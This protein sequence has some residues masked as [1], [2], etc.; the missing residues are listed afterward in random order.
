MPKREARDLAVKSAFVNLSLHK[1]HKPAIALSLH[2]YAE[3][4]VVF[5]PEIFLSTVFLI[6]K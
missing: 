6:S 1:F 2:I 4:L 5:S 3:R